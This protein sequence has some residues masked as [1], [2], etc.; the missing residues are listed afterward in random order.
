MPFILHIQRQN[1]R[2]CG[3]HEQF[4]TLYQAD[5]VPAPGRATKLLPCNAIGSEPVHK[6]ELPLRT[7]PLCAACCD[8][9]RVAEGQ[10]IFAVW[11]DSLPKYQPAT[12]TGS[13]ATTKPKPA[14]KLEDLA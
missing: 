3:A 9:R 14:P 4:S 12:A 1:C 11:H 10:R 5:A 13:T 2:A 6:V 8:E 7:T